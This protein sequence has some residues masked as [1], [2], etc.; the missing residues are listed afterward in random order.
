MIMEFLDYLDGVL[1]YPI[2][3]VVLLVA[4]LYFSFK[5]NFLQIRWFMESIRVVMEKPTKEGSI[6]SFQALM[7]STASRVGTGNIVGVSTALCLGG[8]GALFWMWVIAMIGGSTAFIESTLAQIYKRK[9]ANGDSYGGP[10]YYIEIALKKKSLASAFA[11]FLILTYAGGFNMLASYNL[12][13]TFAGYS[14]YNKAVT[15]WVIGGVLAVLVGYC[16][17]GGGKRIVKFT[18]ILVPFMGLI[19]V[20]LSVV[21]I[22][23]HV[24]MLPGVVGNV[25]SD[26]FNFQKILAGVSGSCLMFGVKRGLYSNEAGVGSAPNAAAA[27]DVAH[28]AQQGLVQM[29]SVIIDT[30]L[31]TS[32]ALMCL[33]SGIA[34][35][36]EL[37]GA[38]YV[39]QATIV[40]FGAIGPVLITVAMVLFA[41]TTLIGNYFYA[42]NCVAYLNGGV[43]PAK[44]TMNTFRIVCAILIFLG[45]GM[46]MAAVWD[47]ADILMAFMC[48]INI[49]SIV[50][51][52]GVALA[53]MKDYGKQ[54]AAGQKPVFKA[55]NIGLS[56]EELHY[57]K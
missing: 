11:G 14:F 5:T 48:F 23:M 52:G 34:P 44:G 40:D 49:P 2:L 54:K 31:C 22:I 13:S 12:Q 7:V 55:A 24:D 10:A 57:W 17:M 4:G 38:P 30:V 1:Y 43:M 18:E 25:L 8:P 19:Y 39:Q 32:T 46:S 9:D 29:L 51:L 21:I 45:A 15:P 6:S 33:F 41:F 28:P 37:A 50:A 35:T 16:L 20:L 36:K 56:T 26:A 3:V 27:A 42:E 53:A 47:I